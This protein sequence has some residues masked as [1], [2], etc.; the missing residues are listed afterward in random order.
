MKAIVYTEFGNSDVIKVIE[1][2]KPAIQDDEVLVKSAAVSVNPADIK[3]RKGLMQQR[4]PVQLPY[5]PGLD[6]AGTIEAVGS[7]VS[8]LKVGDK[9]FGGKMGNTYAEYVALKESNTS[10]IPSN[11]SFSEAAALLVPLVT[12]YSFLIENGE[13]KKGQRLFIQ[14]ITGGTGQVMLQMAKALGLYVI[15]T[16]S[17]SGIALVKSLGADEVIDYKSEDFTSLVKDIDLVI[18][19]VGGETQMNS[20]KTLKKGGKLFS[21]TMPPSQDL[22]K[23]YGVE[24]KFISSTYSYHNLDYGRQL[25]EE[26]KIKPQ[27][28]TAMKLEEAAQAQDLV[29][30]GGINGKVV[31]EIN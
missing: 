3:Y 18:D 13:V 1:M 25:V 7:N 23:E 20:F 31:L 2:Q 27:S 24:A 29:S 9:V 14:G 11:V 22:A 16:A 21:G 8:R 15:G 26:G 5:T 17:P 28:I 6:V 30:T 10:I 12:S 4:L 19:L